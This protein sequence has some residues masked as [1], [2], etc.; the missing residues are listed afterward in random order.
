MA[1]YLSTDERAITA[2][3][4]VRWQA[5]LRSELAELP[6]WHPLHHEYRCQLEALEQRRRRPECVV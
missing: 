3:A 2:R 4:S 1:L 6:D 5:F